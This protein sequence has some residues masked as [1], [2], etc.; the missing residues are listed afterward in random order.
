MLWFI[1]V[2]FTIVAVIIGIRRWKM[3][4]DPMYAVDVKNRKAWVRENSTLIS[5]SEIENKDDT[6]IDDVA[7]NP[8]FESHRSFDTK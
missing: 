7:S 3:A 4:N 8:A 6:L 2:I 1:A 5:D